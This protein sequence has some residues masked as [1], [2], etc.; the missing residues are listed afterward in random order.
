MPKVISP[1]QR[2]RVIEL[3]KKGYPLSEIAKEE[4]ISYKT[5]QRI[6]E[7]Y[8]KEQGFQDL[9]K[10]LK[11]HR[12]K[13]IKELLERI[14]KNARKKIKP[15]EAMENI[16]KNEI[17]DKAIVN[18]AETLSLG[19][20]AMQYLKPLAEEL[21]MDPEQLLLESITYYAG[22]HR[23][24]KE[25]EEELRM[26]KKAFEKI[27]KIFLNPLALWLLRL[28][29]LQHILISYAYRGIK[30]PEDIV[31]EYISLLRGNSISEH[32]GKR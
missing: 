30:P 9:E 13:Q 17:Y 28:N 7:E 23:Y 20:L 12:E 29:K 4:K 6:L 14:R 31:K 24:I 26:Y 15:F 11:E 25:L 18:M 1:K 5:L 19:N 8:A 21:N 27:K 22:K 16:L 10:E 32:G 2:E 3:Y